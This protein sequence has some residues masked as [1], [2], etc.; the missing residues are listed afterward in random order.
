MGQ[1]ADRI[2]G[3]KPGVIQKSAPIFAETADRK[4]HPLEGSGQ[5]AI[6]LP[7]ITFDSFWS[8]VALN[9]ATGDSYTRCPRPTA[10]T[11]VCVLP[12]YQCCVGRFRHIPP[13]CGLRRTLVFL[14]VVSASLC[15]APATHQ[16]QGSLTSRSRARRQ[17]LA[18]SGPQKTFG[19]LPCPSVYSVQRA[20]L[21]RGS[22]FSR[23]HGRGVARPPN[24]VTGHLSR[25]ETGTHQNGWLLTNFSP[26]L[27]PQP[28]CGG[29]LSQ[30]LSA[31]QKAPDPA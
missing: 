20:W 19:S 13:D 4:S 21:P 16:A 10:V 23:A 31:H 9:H 17:P 5:E 12:V 11:C 6:P 14:V 27:Q 29:T 24:P 8:G 15:A 22:N 28:N 7:D 30:T 25:V 18:R 26:S 2:F 1:R 3:A